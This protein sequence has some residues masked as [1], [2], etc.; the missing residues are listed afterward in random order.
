VDSNTARAIADSLGAAYVL[1]GRVSTGLR[2]R[3]VTFTLYNGSTGRPLMYRTLT[4]DSARVLA[5]EQAAA[6]QVVTQ[7]VG[8]PKPGEQRA[9]DRTG[10]TN[11]KAYDWFIR[12]TAAR[13][14]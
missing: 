3:T 14:V 8:K 2:G 7:I 9:L 1:G 11:A 13:D 10:T 6:A 5:V 4:Q 12:G